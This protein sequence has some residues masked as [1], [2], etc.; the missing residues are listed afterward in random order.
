MNPSG[1]PVTMRPDQRINQIV[2]LIKIQ[3]GRRVRIKHGRMID[4]GSILL[5]QRLNRQI[6]N[7]QI[8]AHQGDQLRR[9]IIHNRRLHAAVASTRQGT[10]TAAPWG[11]CGT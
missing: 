4:V 8:C 3:L 1:Q 10:S 7:I 9:N 2:D 5:Q 11:S 6:L